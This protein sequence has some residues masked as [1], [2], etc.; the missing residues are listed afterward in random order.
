MYHSHSINFTELGSQVNF[1]K[2]YV[3]S[4]SKCHDFVSLLLREV[5]QSNCFIIKSSFFNQASSRISLI[6]AFFSSSHIW[7]FHFGATRSI[8]PDRA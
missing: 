6:A 1:I 4:L 8:L 3:T 5:V 7:I 2:K